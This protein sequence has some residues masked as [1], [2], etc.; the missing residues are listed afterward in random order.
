MPYAARKED[1]LFGTR[2]EAR[3]VHYTTAE[4]ALSIIKSK[5]IWMRNTT[6]MADYREVQHGFD[7]L[8][9]FFSDKSKLGAFVFALDSCAAGV[10]MEAINLFNGWW[11]T[12]WLNTYITSISEHDPE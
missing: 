6:C 12:I 3:F 1:A 9:G 4:A 10:A 8:R 2:D 5:R 11:N 7:M